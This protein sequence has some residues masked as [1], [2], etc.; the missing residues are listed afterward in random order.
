ME[1]GP[2]F[3]V[4]SYKNDIRQNVAN[5]C[6]FSHHIGQTSPIKECWW[7]RNGAFFEE[8]FEKKKKATTHV[9][10]HSN[11]W[12]TSSLTCAPARRA[13]TASLVSRSGEETVEAFFA[14]TV[15]CQSFRLRPKRERSTPRC[16]SQ[17][18]SPREE[19][20]TQK[21]RCVSVSTCKVN[22]WYRHLLTSLAL[23]RMSCRSVFAAGCWLLY[24]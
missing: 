10:G 11:H 23:V 8:F 19:R 21:M 4:L 12:F 3:C 1:R 9:P 6:V 7:S 24:A 14:R 5:F 17:H 18:S 2:F 15:H 16:V 22:V 13:T 20:L